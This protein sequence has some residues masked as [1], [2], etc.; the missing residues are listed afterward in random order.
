[1]TAEEVFQIYSKDM[2]YMRDIQRKQRK[3]LDILGFVTLA[4]AVTTVYSLMTG[5]C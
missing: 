5:H 2:L 4:L 1:M 3:L